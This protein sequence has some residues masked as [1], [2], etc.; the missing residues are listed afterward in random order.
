LTDG[1][2]YLLTGEFFTGFDSL[3]RFELH[4][5]QHMIMFGFFAINPI[6]ELMYFYK[7]PAIPPQLDYVSA[8]VALVVEGFLFKFHLEGRNHID[9]QVR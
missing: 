6:F 2:I 3:G 8:I 7:V 4:N 1:I 5:G 9:H